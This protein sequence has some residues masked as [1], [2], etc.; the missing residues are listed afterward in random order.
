MSYFRMSGQLFRPF[1]K[2]LHGLPEV[3]LVSLLLHSGCSRRASISSAVIAKEIAP[4]PPRVGAITVTFRLADA[5]KPVT[6][7]HVDLEGDM[8]HAG[9]AP[10]FGKAREIAPGQYQGKLAVNMAG[11]WIVLLHVTLPNGEKLEDQ[12]SVR[13]V[14]SQ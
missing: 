7:A 8:T 12:V 11:D 4:Q 2:V 5:A 1:E 10:V 6:G 13:G 14:Q 9:M 3:L